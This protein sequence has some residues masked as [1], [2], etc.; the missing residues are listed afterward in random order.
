[1]YYNFKYVF[2]LKYINQIFLIFY[3]LDVIILIFS[4]LNKK[5]ASS[6]FKKKS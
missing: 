6:K 1:M 5:Y 4:L 2:L 3:N